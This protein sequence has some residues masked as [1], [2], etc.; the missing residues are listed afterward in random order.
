MGNDID[1]ST[2]AYDD[3][4]AW[5]PTI[6]LDYAMGPRLEGDEYVLGIYDGCIYT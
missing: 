4:A 1:P 3:R 2:F 5:Q 6:P